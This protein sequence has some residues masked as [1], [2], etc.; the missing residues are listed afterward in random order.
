VG[1]RGGPVGVERRKGMSDDLISARS[2]P[3]SR[4]WGVCLLTTPHTQTSKFMF[5]V[6]V[7]PIKL[8]VAMR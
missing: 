5:V 7:A 4:A 1:E 6:H 8:L 3:A 2:R